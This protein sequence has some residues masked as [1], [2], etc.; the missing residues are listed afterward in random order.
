MLET[1]KKVGDV[2]VDGLGN[3]YEIKSIKG[4]IVISESVG[5]VVIEPED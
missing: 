5:K 1:N 4:T 3:E 2:W